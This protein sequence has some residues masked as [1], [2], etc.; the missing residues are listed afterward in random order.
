MVDSF[1]ASDD[2]EIVATDTSA[3]EADRKTVR[4]GIINAE[5]LDVHSIE[6]G[7]LVEHTRA[8]KRIFGV[9]LE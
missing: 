4:L 7:V 2:R 3:L 5:H 8:D 9:L 1:W 6:N